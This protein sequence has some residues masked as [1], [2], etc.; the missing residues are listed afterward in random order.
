MKPEIGIWIDIPRFLAI[1]NY[2]PLGHCP[3]TCQFRN[4]N[5]LCPTGPARI[6]RGKLFCSVTVKKVARIYLTHRLVDFLFPNLDEQ[7]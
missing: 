5:T 6:V 4:I 3:I 7:K 1:N 2:T